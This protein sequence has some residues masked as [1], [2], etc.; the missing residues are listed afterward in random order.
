[1]RLSEATDMDLWEAGI[2]SLAELAHDGPALG[3]PEHRWC[4]RESHEYGAQHVEDGHRYEVC[5][6]CHGVRDMG[7]I[8]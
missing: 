4:F 7:R 8:S 3:G 2:V 5:A 6:R 1:M